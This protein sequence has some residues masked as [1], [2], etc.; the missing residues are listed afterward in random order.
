M[1]VVL[2]QFLCG[3]LCVLEATFCAQKWDV[4]SKGLAWEEGADL[5]EL[6]QLS[7]PSPLPSSVVTELWGTIVTAYL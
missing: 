6:L 7:F 4:M 3:F 1:A 5:T 2:K